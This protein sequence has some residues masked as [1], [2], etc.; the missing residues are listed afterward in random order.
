M[1]AY[2]VRP[3]HFKCTFIASGSARTVYACMSHEAD[4]RECAEDRARVEATSPAERDS[5]AVWC[6][7][8]K[9]G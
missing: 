8:C 7:F 3:G 1:S 5:A 9:V 6:S 4:I 2:A